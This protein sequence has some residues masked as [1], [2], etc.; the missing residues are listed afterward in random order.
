[1]TRN[2]ECGCDNCLQVYNPNWAIGKEFNQCGECGRILGDKE[3]CTVHLDDM[4]IEKQLNQSPSNLNP[5]FELDY[6]KPVWK[7]LS[8]GELHQ[9]GW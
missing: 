8:C 9:G 4:S 1:M 2:N 5:D 6:S 3:F 7:C